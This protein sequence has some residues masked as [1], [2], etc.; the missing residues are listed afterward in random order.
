METLVTKLQQP[1]VCNECA[2]SDHTRSVSMTQM[3]TSSLIRSIGD[4]KRCPQYIHFPARLEGQTFSLTMKGVTST[5]YLQVAP[6]KRGKGEQVRIAASEASDVYK[7][8][9]YQKKNSKWA[10]KSQRTM[11][12]DVREA[13][14]WYRPCVRPHK[15]MTL[16]IEAEK[17]DL[18]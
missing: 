9:P 11:R 10:P 8:D 6:V 15:K 5:T 18:S 13:D 1:K 7:S 12:I 2:G 17:G 14:E 3:T 4:G 16:S